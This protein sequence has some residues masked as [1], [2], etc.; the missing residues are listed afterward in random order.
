MLLQKNHACTKSEQPVAVQCKAFCFDCS[1]TRLC[2]E[3]SLVVTIV[4][5]CRKNTDKCNSRATNCR[6]ITHETL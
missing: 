5:V 2:R 3:I 4:F 1:T 6:E